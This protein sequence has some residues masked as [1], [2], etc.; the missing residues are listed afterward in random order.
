MCRRNTTI[1]AFPQSKRD[2][3]SHEICILIPLS[4]DNTCPPAHMEEF[5]PYLPNT[6]HSLFSIIDDVGELVTIVR[7]WFVSPTRR[8][9]QA[10]VT[11]VNETSHNICRG[12]W[13]PP[14]ML[15]TRAILGQTFLYWQIILQWYSALCQ[16][17]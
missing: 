14:R 8:R 6:N 7:V 3:N 12:T 17:Q 13:V 9:Y 15:P 5:L 1:A 2:N 16:S 4:N 11:Q 10:V